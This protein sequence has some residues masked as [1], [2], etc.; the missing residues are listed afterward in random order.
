MN[1]EKEVTVYDGTKE[2]DSQPTESM[3]AHVLSALGMSSLGKIFSK[4]SEKLTDEKLQSPTEKKLELNCEELR[5]RKEQ[6]RKS[7]EKPLEKILTEAH[8]RYECGVD[9]EENFKEEEMTLKHKDFEEAAESIRIPLGSIL[10]KH[11]EKGPPIKDEANISFEIVSND[12]MKRTRDVATPELDQEIENAPKRTAVE[13]S[14]RTGKWRLPL[15][16][17]AN[18]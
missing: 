1:P 4:D 12:A 18:R 8:D 5:D 2:L 16:R 7:V 10:K 13:W 3:A 14:S 15:T 6:A 11:H 17:I 9:V